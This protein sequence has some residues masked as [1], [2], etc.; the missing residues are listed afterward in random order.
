MKYRINVDEFGMPFQRGEILIRGR[1]SLLTG[2]NGEPG[3]VYTA[4]NGQTLVFYDNEVIPDF[5]EY[6]NAL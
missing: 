6:I 4:K 5:N 2:Q 1:L 3:Y